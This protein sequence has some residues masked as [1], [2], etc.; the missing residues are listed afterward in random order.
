M[1]KVDPHTVVFVH[2]G[3]EV[4]RRDVEEV[5][6]GERHEE[7]HVDAKGHQIRED[8]TEQEGEGR[9]HSDQQRTP[10]LHLSV[11]NPPYLDYIL[12]GRKTV[13]SRFSVVRCAPYG[14]VDEGDLLLLKQSSGPIVGVCMVDRVWSYEL[15]P[16]TFDEIRDTFAEMLCAED[17]KFWDM[18]QRAQYATLMRISH[19]TAIN[20][21]H[22]E[23][24]DRRGW[25]ILSS[26]LQQ[27]ELA[28]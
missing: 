24:R 3:N 21:V 18:R 13:E 7:G 9:Q 25:V 23:K 8:A 10:T 14:R 15:E 17:P 27:R 28:L 22:C 26:D 2:L 12:E 20:P 19:A 1:Q 5:P 16:S 4:R 11:F 6:S